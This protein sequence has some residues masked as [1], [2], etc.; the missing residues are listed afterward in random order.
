MPQTD[1]KFLNEILIVIVAPTYVPST[2][3]RTLLSVEKSVATNQLNPKK[4]KVILLTYKSYTIPKKLYKAAQCPSKFS[5][6]K[7]VTN[8]CCLKRNIQLKYVNIINTFT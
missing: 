3:Y 7:I 4:Q 1:S 2:T 6:C 5:P 8:F